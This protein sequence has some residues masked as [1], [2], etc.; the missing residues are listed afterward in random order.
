MTID[1]ERVNTSKFNIRQALNSVGANIP[2]DTPLDQYP[3]YI[4][5]L[6][7]GGDFDMAT[8]TFINSTGEELEFTGVFIE[9]QVQAIDLNI[10]IMDGETTNSLILYNGESP[11]LLGFNR[12]GK[13]IAVT[14]NAS[15]F[16]EEG[17]IRV[18]GDCTITITS[19]PS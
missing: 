1:Q 4:M 7:G 2:V 18:T 14:D 3:P 13:T 5:G 11:I 12:E 15:Y 10:F 9:S 19:N 8:V 6:S 16:P 17:A